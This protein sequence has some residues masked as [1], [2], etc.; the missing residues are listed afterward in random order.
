M[1]PLPVGS[2]LG[3][4][5]GV[6]VVDVNSRH[7][8]WSFGLEGGGGAVEFWDPRSRNALTRLV[9]PA[10]TLLPAQSFDVAS[11]IAQPVPTLSVTA[12][13]SHPTDGLSLAVGTSSGHTLLYDLRSPTPFAVKD[14]GYGEPIKCVDWV[15]GGG[16]QEDGGRVVS[17][18]SKVIK[19]W[20]K[21]DVSCHTGIGFQT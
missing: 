17:A 14:Q 12:L 2:G 21:D 3:D 13:A 11:I 4:V 1:T 6:N 16:A 9:L 19:I 5:Q 8:L 20:G 15:L 18:D 10:S 7:G